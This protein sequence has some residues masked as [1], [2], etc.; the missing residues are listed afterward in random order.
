MVV[1]RSESLTF[2]P[3]KGWMNLLSKSFA[4]VLSANVR[5]LL[6]MTTLTCEAEVPAGC[7]V[8][9]DWMRLRV[10]VFRGLFGKG[11]ELGAP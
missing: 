8:L 2:V 3:G 4:V 11:V 10:D 6:S 9:G 7:N 5:W 1:V